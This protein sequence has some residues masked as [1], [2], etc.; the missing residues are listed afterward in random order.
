MARG[1][2]SKSIESQQEEAAE[3]RAKAR[4]G[5]QLNADEASKKRERELLLLARA[6]VV[7]Q[8]EASQN[9]RHAE[10][11]NRALQELDSK[12]AKLE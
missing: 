2:E 11:L 7:Q 5:A 3:D 4:E 1:W 6:S 8:I 12:V 9:P 10:M